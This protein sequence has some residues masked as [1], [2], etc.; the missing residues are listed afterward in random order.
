M[1]R[2]SFGKSL[3]AILIVAHVALVSCSEDP[4]GND[5][6]QQPAL[7]PAASMTVDF[8]TLTNPSSMPKVAQPGLNYLNA[9]AR[10]AIINASVVI[11]MSVPVAVFVAAFSQTPTLGNDGKYHW[12]YSTSTSGNSFTADLSGSV[13]LSTQESVWEMRISS[14]VLSL[15]NFLWYDGRAKLNN[16]SGYWDFYDP[17]QPGSK[18]D[19]L[20][21]DWTYA[22]TSNATLS[23]EVV[24]DGAPEKGDSLNYAVAGNNLTVSF[25]DASASETTEISWDK[26][27]GAGYLIAPTYNGG[28]K[29]CWD[30]TKADVVCQ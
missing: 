24:K 4:A 22:S 27:T 6:P 12:K 1:H 15:N 13:D 5:K 3:A 11:V 25:F 2:K 16:S 17:A 14:T 7:P 18:V 10:V 23:F 29:A 9:A 21:L 8:S 28:Q 20:H 30:S 19:V 26:T